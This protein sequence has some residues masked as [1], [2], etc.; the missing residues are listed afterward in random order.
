MQPGSSP[1]YK[2]LMES[3]HLL[4]SLMVCN[5][6]LIFRSFDGSQSGS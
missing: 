1:V 6:V 2:D 4:Y 5:D 3:I